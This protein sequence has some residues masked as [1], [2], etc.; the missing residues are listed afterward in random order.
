MRIAAGFHFSAR[1]RVIMLAA[2]VFAAAMLCP[3]TAA[4]AA[5]GDVYVYRVVN[6]YNHEVR[7]HIAYRVDY[8]GADRFFLSVTPDTPLLGPARTEVYA[9]NGNWL[10]HTVINH[11]QPIEYEF[12]QE[13]PAYVFPLDRGKSWSLRVGAIDPVSNQRVSVRVDAEVL[14]TE[15]IVTP[16]G[17]FDTIKVRR[18]VYAGDAEA[19]RQETTIDET[20]WY[21]PVLGRPVRS[22]SNSGY[23]NPS[24]CGRGACRPVRGDWNLF[25]LIQTSVAR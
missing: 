3:R 7:G 17:A 13:Y 10:L 23:M 24:R 2:A 8:V 9:L 18:R 15:R 22:E 19:F 14:G 4:A 20:E 21:A 16:A 1:A 6:G 11:D 25:E 5:V 12:V